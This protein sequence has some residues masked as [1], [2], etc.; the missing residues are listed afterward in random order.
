MIKE[1]HRPYLQRYGEAS[2]HLSNYR[3]AQRTKINE[4][5]ERNSLEEEKF[6]AK[7]LDKS[8]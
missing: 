7:F 8:K 4:K 6:V 3:S 2:I 1:N 5:H